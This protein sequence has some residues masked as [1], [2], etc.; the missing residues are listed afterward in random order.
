MA[1]HNE[2]PCRV[3]ADLRIHDQEQELLVRHFDLAN[4]AEDA[5]ET[6]HDGE[7][8]KQIMNDGDLAGPIAEILAGFAVASTEVGR[9]PKEMLPITKLLLARV[10]TLEKIL[11]NWAMD[12]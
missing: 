4:Q 10:G 11:F 5:L 9:L 6:I 3:S 12:R 1:A 7:K 2:A 8:L